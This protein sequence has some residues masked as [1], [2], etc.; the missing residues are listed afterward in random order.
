MDVPHPER[1]ARLSEYF[2]ALA[3]LVPFKHYVDTDDYVDVRS[4]KQKER[5]QVKAAFKQ[6]H[7][8]AKRAKL[9]PDAEISTTKVQQDMDSD[10]GQNGAA[11]LAPWL[12]ASRAGRALMPADPAA[13]QWSS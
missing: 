4:M 9:D 12:V 13:L 2:D 1:I 7:K 6:Q 11:P 3:N 5:V 8:F 10:R